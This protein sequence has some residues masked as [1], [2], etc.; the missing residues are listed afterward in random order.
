MC[1]DDGGDATFHIWQGPPRQTINRDLRCDVSAHVEVTAEATALPNVR[2]V[3]GLIDQRAHGLG[4]DQ[5]TNGA[6]F[7]VVTVQQIDALKPDPLVG[8]G[9]LRANELLLRVQ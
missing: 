9:V 5:A 3:V 2:K 8:G 4:A 1:P 6:R 7:T